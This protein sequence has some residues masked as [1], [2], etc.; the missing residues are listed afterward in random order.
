M[1]AEGK[2][3]LARPGA[4]GAP[5][6]VQIKRIR[7]IMST[8]DIARASHRLAWPPAPVAHPGS[9]GIAPSS[10]PLC[11]R[12]RGHGPCGLPQ[13]H[14]TVTPPPLGAEPAPL[15]SSLALTAAL[16]FPQ[17]PQT[18]RAP[19]NNFGRSRNSLNSSEAE[20]HLLPPA[21]TVLS[22]RC[23][24]HLLA[25]LG[26][27]GCDRRLPTDLNRQE[28]KCE[29]LEPARQPNLRSARRPAALTPK[30]LRYP[31]VV[32]AARGTR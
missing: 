23:P 19:A 24:P 20:R 8:N 25:A 26:S 17:R 32:W 13:S 31:Q 4:L 12:L 3:G 27:S 7:Y 22:S 9:P 16:T 1:A 2:R 5:A 11:E 30:R 14:P 21:P 15:S 6:G 18:S 28:L 29:E 10:P